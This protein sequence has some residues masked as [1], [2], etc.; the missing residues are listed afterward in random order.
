MCSSVS[1]SEW[2]FA[3]T[4]GEALD[5]RQPA[6]TKPGEWIM[7]NGHSPATTAGP[8]TTC[9]HEANDAVCLSIDKMHF[10]TK[11]EAI[12]FIKKL[13]PNTSIRE[14]TASHRCKAALEELLSNKSLH[15]MRLSEFD[16]LPEISTD[17]FVAGT[18]LVGAVVAK[19]LLDDTKACIL[20]VD[21]GAQLSAVPGG[22]LK[23]SAYFQRNVDPFA[24][25]I[26]G[27]MH[28]LSVSVDHAPVPTLGPGAFQ[29]PKTSLGRYERANQNPDQ[30]PWVN[31][32]G[33]AATYAVG[34]MGTHWTAACPRQ[35]PD[36]EQ[37]DLYTSTEWD[38][39]YVQAEKFY[40]VT[41][42]AFERSIRHQ[43][44]KKKLQETYPELEAPYQPQAIPLAV[45][46]RGKFFEWSST[47]TVLGDWVKSPNC[48]HCAME[49]EPHDPSQRLTIREQ[50]I[51][52][53]LIYGPNEH[54]EQEVKFALVEN[55][56]HNKLYKV[57]AKHFVAACGTVLSAQ[58][59]H[60]SNIRPDA[61]GRYLSEQPMCF[62]QVVM[63]EEMIEE[64][65]QNPDYNSQV[66]AH[67]H[68]N[69]NDPVPFPLDDPEP[70]C[71]IPV[72]KDRP[73]HC[74]IHRD[75]FAY[76]DVAPNVD[77]RLIVDLRWFGIVKQ[78]RDNRVTFSDTVEDVFGMP[79]PTF[80]YKIDHEEGK[81]LRDMM[82][83]MQRCASS[84][85]P[86]LPGASPQFMDPG[87]PVHIHG[88]TRMGK[89]PSSSV[90]TPESKVHGTSN[91]F[92][93]GLGT[94][95]TDLACNPTLTAA[96]IAIHSVEQA[97]GP[98]YQ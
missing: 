38:A 63:S 84:F 34:G 70:N 32:A 69:P 39:L 79:Q 31:M 83:D 73:W 30:D 72:S 9:R 41:Q 67:S 95:P 19:K 22:H 87:L 29:V 65:K 17:V 10:K 55:L 94:I 58:L 33:A 74:Q 36:L 59:L 88:V 62:C 56:V 80:H 81:T 91:L 57:K 7:S 68:R 3:G 28:K 54:G 37:S 12:E 20:M 23:N 92:I 52:R 13:P 42:S 16:C 48:F 21:P 2:V 66:W 51:C 27:H 86:F 71:W 49:D 50:T 53:K 6:T 8:G 89:D 75:A 77:S 76:G 96:A 5:A 60:A 25:V 40:G 45:R 85:G 61:L 93:A 26:R 4:D 1:E 97:I 24:G 18:G 44:V 78:S 64:V 46:P 11:D 14:P 82:T 90:V 35:H 47:A 98:A 43:A 15:S